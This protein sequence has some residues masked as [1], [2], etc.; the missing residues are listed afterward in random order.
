[1]PDAFDRLAPKLL[2]V[3]GGY[4][5]RA[6]DRGG[7]TMWGITEAT[8]RRYGYSGDM[9]SLP[10][11]RALQIYRARYWEEPNFNWVSTVSDGVAAELFDTG[12]NC[13]QATAAMMLQRALNVLYDAAPI[14]VDGDVGPATIGRLKAY[15]KARPSD[16][17]SILLV[18]LN[19]LQ[20]ERYIHIA[21]TDPSQRKNINGWLKQR[22]SI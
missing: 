13:G 6:E 16:G 12:V 14:R 4:S 5:N 17:E 2:S 22:V 1:M 21:E 3:E 15:L 11:E 9:R 7:P 20:G 19:C 18:S 8:A 10:R